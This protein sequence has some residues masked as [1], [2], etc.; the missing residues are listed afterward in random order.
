M[1]ALFL[2]LSDFDLGCT[3]VCDSERL[4]CYSLVVSKIWIALRLAL[5][6]LW[7][8]LPFTFLFILILGNFQGGRFAFGDGILFLSVFY[9]GAD[10]SGA[11]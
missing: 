6:F 11:V 10:R 3:S 8:L 4:N 5:F 9:D 1:L 2:T 7:L